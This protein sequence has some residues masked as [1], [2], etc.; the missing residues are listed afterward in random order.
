MP[1]PEAGAMHTQHTVS[2]ETT[3]TEAPFAYL[4]RIE[5]SATVTQT[6]SDDNREV[7]NETWRAYLA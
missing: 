5:R 1:G 4:E 3:V 7:T 6:K 2:W